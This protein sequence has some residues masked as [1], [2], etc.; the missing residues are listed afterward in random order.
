VDAV[1]HAGQDGPIEG[2]RHD[3]D[4]AGEALRVADLGVLQTTLVLKSE[5]MVCRVKDWRGT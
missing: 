2:E 1:P 3:E 5:N 4:E